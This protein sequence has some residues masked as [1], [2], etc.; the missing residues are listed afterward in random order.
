[1]DIPSTI[2]SNHL[3]RTLSQYDRTVESINIKYTLDR[4][5]TCTQSALLNSRMVNDNPHLSAR[6]LI[7]IIEMPMSISSVHLPNIPSLHS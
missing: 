7:D 1:M 3:H 2:S 4:V 6:T 5:D